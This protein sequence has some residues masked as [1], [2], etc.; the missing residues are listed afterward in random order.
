MEKKK[1]RIVCKNHKEKVSL[2]VLPTTTLHELLLILID[3]GCVDTYN[4][5]IYYDKEDNKI[6]E[7]FYEFIQTDSILREN[8]EMVIK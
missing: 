4:E 1:I 2:K 3:N 5:I 6:P 7:E 8:N